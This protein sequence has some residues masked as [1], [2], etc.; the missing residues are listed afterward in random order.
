MTMTWRKVLTMGCLLAAFGCKTQQAPLMPGSGPAPGPTSSDMPLDRPETKTKVPTKTDETPKKEDEPG[1]KRFM[2][3]E[4]RV[5][6]ESSISP[7]PDPYKPRPSSTG[8]SPYGSASPSYPYESSLPGSQPY[9]GDRTSGTQPPYTG[10]GSPY[11]APPTGSSP[12]GGYSPNTGLSPGPYGS[13]STG[14]SP[15]AGPSSG[16]SPYG[17]STT[18]GGST[19]YGGYTSGR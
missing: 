18:G 1:Y 2:D 5:K 11:G 17:T 14:G 13:T 6:S 7:Y 15:Y 4:K 8:G 9:N 16:G 12:Y 10:T 3:E 19:G